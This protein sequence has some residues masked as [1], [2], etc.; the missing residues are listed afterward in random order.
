MRRECGYVALAAAV[1]MLCGTAA[2][3]DQQTQQ[4]QEERGAW[5]DSL[6]YDEYLGDRD[7]Q[8]SELIDA[9]VQNPQ[10]EEL[11]RVEDLL[12][13]RDGDVAQVVIAVGGV[14]GV[15]QKRVTVPYEELRVS[16]DGETLFIARTREELEAL[17][18][19]RA[20]ADEAGLAEGAAAQ[21]EAAA[22]QLAVQQQEGAQAS[23]EEQAQ[24]AERQAE[25]QVEQAE[26]REQQAARQEQQAA[27]QEQQA[28]QQAQQAEAQQ[29][30]AAQQ[31]EQAQQQQQ[32]QERAAEEAQQRAQPSQRVTV[33]DRTDRRAS[34][35]IGMTV[36]D[37]R[38]EEIGEI[39]DLVVSPEDG[40]IFAVLAIGGV[41]GIGERLISVPLEDLEL[42]T[43]G[44]EPREPGVPGEPSENAARL[45]MTSEQLIE[46]Q[47]E[48]QYSTDERTAGIG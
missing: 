31:A 2:G 29:Q 9:R 34:E 38:G 5:A 48:F 7:L 32:E 42:T 23:S 25:Q 18:E 15:G 37:S 14:L 27:E 3:Q 30:R 44:V 10:G 1:A 6:A 40:R 45:K 47:P 41:I 13:S 39:D 21:R 22:E 4:Q 46:T 17:P 16:R 35:L 43:P 33:M 28:A 24:R 11:G 19:Y 20:Q 36:V 12:V 8:A 26:E